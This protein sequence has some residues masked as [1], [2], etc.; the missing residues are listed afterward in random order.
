M[1]DKKTEAEAAATSSRSQNVVRV[2]PRDWSS[3]AEVITPSMER[4]DGT[5]AATQFL[6]VTPD[7]SS[8]F[9]VVRGAFE[10]FGTVGIDLFPATAEHRAARLMAG[11]PVPAVAG[12][13]E[14]LRALMA[15]SVLRVDGVKSVLFTWIEDVIEA[16]GD[17][18]AALE[19]VLAE[20]PETASR[21]LVVREVTPAVQSFIDRYMFRA[22][23]ATAAVVTPEGEEPQPMAME[24]V[25]TPSAARPASLWRL[26]DELDPPSAVV[27]AR[28]PES[29]ADAKRTLAQLGY[30]RGD[31]PVTVSTAP[32]GENVHT[33]VF[34][35]PPLA[36]AD[37]EAARAVTAAR[38]IAFVEAGDLTGLKQ[39]T[40]GLAKPLA[41][42]DAVRQARR[43]DDTLRAELRQVLDT[44]VA[45]REMTALEP[46]LEQYDAVEVAAAL[47]RL[48]EREREHALTVPVA[49]KPPKPAREDRPPRREE[50]PPRGRDDRPPRSRDDRPPRGRDD[51]PPRGRDD[52]PPRS[53]PPRDSGRYAGRDSGRAGPPRGRGGDRGGS[54]R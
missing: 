9:A 28:H 32:A 5:V 30:R 33:I 15:R 42:G 51:R 25:T 31:D 44:G 45:F 34:Y 1:T 12:P 3:L 13:P 49:P 48:L 17:Q 2:L 52:R 8:T 10:R 16:G 7:P 11:V 43:K 35:D 19:A 27:I 54:R 46:L 37:V 23:R 29:Q 4:I 20:V 14:V 18:L 36:Q 41:V 22:R 47:L 39:L 53:G 40:G 50:R 38:V 6:V 26:L 21:T 24:Y